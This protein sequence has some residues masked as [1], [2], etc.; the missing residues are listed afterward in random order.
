M[1]ASKG[2]Q[3]GHWILGDRLGGGG[4]GVVFAAS[5]GEE[6]GAIKLLRK[7][8]A[9][10]RLRFADEVSAMRRCMDIPGVLPI[11]D[12]SDLHD[13]AGSQPW[14]VMARAS[15]IR[16]A[17]SSRP[18]L[19]LVVEAIGQLATTLATMHARGVSHRDL[20]PEN[21]FL[22]QNRWSVGDF[23]LAAFAGKSHKTEV[24]KRIG[25]I[26]YIAPEMLNSATT[27]SGMPADVF[28]L[29]KTLWV[30]ATGQVFP[31]P[32]QYMPTQDA[33]RIGSYVMEDGTSSLDTLI[34]ACTAVDPNSR[35]TMQQMREELTAWQAPKP[36][37]APP[38]TLDVSAFKARLA[39]RAAQLK[40]QRERERED[41]QLAHASG[42]RLRERLRPLARDIE[43]SLNE[44]GFESVSVSLDNMQW[45][46]DIGASVPSASRH[47]GV[48]LSFAI[49]ASSVFPE[50][51]LNCRYMIEVT[52][53][54]PTA[55]L[56]WHKEMKYMP[57]GPR[58][59]IVL[60]SLDQTARDH[61][62]MAANLALELGFDPTPDTVADAARSVMVRDRS[63][64]PVEG[65]AVFLIARN[66][67]FRRDITNQIGQAAFT[68]F[69]FSPVTAF[70]AA[71]RYQALIED[72]KEL[73]QE[74]TLDVDE[75][76]V[77]SFVA[78]SG[79]TSIPTIDGELNFILDAQGRR[80][81]Y[82][83]GVAINGGARQPVA[84]ALGA[85]L[86][87]QS[88]DGSKAT[89]LPRAF[90]GACFL[91]DIERT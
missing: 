14:F 2:R 29:A 70:I 34:A 91:L 31:L 42:L 68:S 6:A 76:V 38:V 64:K 89:I 80:Y 62:Q 58:E 41:Q 18:N 66:G 17:L 83:N 54:N 82:A 33:F 37:P 25:P 78:T 63:G 60:A 27:S 69:P 61:L 20:K 12:S 67:L 4:N 44:V 56:A 57:E 49:H 59:D 15:P 16:D 36:E 22:Y 75:S 88:K 46:L 21:L 45:G 77:G 10:R 8:S 53:D 3:Y 86:T 79:W 84:V 23:G 51:L 65:A 55:L 73:N 19:R 74:V 28:S 1:P 85:R 81:V 26:Y 48:R 11:L 39:A 32:G 71:E 5:R 35:P 9:S 50:V 72:L 87:L 13:D 7:D 47:R 43:K 24:G 90:C 52:G 40:A 30:L